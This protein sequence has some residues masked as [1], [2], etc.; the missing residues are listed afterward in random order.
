[1]SKRSAHTEAEV[2]QRSAG[3]RIKLIAGGLIAVLAVV[4]YYT[5]E[6]LPLLERVAIVLVGLSVGGYLVYLTETGQRAKRFLSEMRKELR[7]VVWPT[8]KETLQTTL[9]IIAVVIVMGFFL[10]LVDMFFLW[11]VELLTGRGG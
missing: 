7:L 6:Q 4:A 2:Q 3:D 5:Q 8:R 10:W 1:M 9:M 11:A